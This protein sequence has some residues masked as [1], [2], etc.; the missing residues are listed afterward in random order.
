MTIWCYADIW[1]LI[2]AEQPDRAAVIQGDR[3]LS[4][5]QFDREADSLAAAMV[6]A[7]AG[8]Q[9]KV[10]CYLHNSP[11]YLTATFAAYKAGMVPFNV[12]Y[13]YGHDE[14]AYLLDNADAEVVVFDAEFASKLEPLRERLPA[15][16]LWA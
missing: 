15:V 4:W 9:A 5:R 14:L 8:R 13:R 1:E 10:A 11:E 7:G 12:N 3:I 2:A 6:E 16:K